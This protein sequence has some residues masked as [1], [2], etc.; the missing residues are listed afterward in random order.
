MTTS[1]AEMPT[2]QA[3]KRL[4]PVARTPEEVRA[5]FRRLADQWLDE[6]QVVSSLTEI[7]LHPAYQ[8]VIGMG[9]AA[10]PLIMRELEDE[11]APWFWALQSITG[12]NPVPQEDAGQFRKMAAAWVN[13][14]RGRGYV[15]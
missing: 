15:T 4:L 8:Q 5:K 6:T 1:T 14:G 11:P 13:W 12:E 3:T 10:V 9:E 7:V 2:L